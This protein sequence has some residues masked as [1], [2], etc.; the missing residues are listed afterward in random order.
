MGPA[1]RRGRGSGEAGSFDHIQCYR[2]PS[3]AVNVSAISTRVSTAA[4]IRIATGLVTGVPLAAKAATGSRSQSDW[5]VCPNPASAA[6]T[7][8]TTGPVVGGVPEVPRIRMVPTMEEI[9]EFA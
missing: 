7:G 2:Q 3:S 4:G 9:P 1:S 8:P 5:P 6:V